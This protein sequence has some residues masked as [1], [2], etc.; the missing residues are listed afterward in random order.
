MRVLAALLALG[1]SALAI[2]PVPRKSPEFTIVDP[3]GKQ[4]T[5]LS[6]LKGKV[7]LL[8]FVLAN[9]PHCVRA[10]TTIDKVY[11][12]LGPRGFEPVGI[13][14]QPNLPPRMVTDLARQLGVSYPIGCSSPEAVDT[15]LGRSMMERLMVPQIV[16]I[17][18]QGVIRAQSGSNGDPLL[19]NEVYLRTLIGSLL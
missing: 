18:R 9:C 7:V 10:S 16:V 14:F 6:S 5:L 11:R 15:Y 19:E 2:S 17:D 4:Q 1:A 8:E 3:S 12:D 13:A